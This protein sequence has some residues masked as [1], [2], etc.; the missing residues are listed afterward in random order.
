VPESSGSEHKNSEKKL[1]LKILFKTTFC[2][3]ANTSLTAAFMP[4]RTTT[5]TFFR[6]FNIV[7]VR[8]KVRSVATFSFKKEE[9][10]FKK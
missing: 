7:A 8:D 4:F 3:A 5:S 6:A 1:F 9:I 10:L 2:R